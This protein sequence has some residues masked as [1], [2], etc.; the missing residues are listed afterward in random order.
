[1]GGFPRREGGAAAAFS[2]FHP[3][4]KQLAVHSVWTTGASAGETGPPGAGRAH[5]TVSPDPDP[6]SHW[7]TAKQCWKSGR[8]RFKSQVCC[9]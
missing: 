4:L 2:P 1:M 9:H 6:G 3:M 5:R 7:G 8:T